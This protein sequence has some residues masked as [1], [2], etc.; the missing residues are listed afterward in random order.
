MPVVNEPSLVSFDANRAMEVLRETLGD[1]LLVV[2][3]YDRDGFNT[4]YVADVIRALYPDEG[5]M[6]E[7]FAGIHAY[8]YLDFTERELFED[9]FIESGGTRA[10]VTYMVNLVAIRVVRE[11]EGLF[12]SAVPGT[13][14]TEL[15]EL[16]EG[17]IR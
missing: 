7:H 13:P 1:D 5:A 11:T 15:V 4:L 16:V 12:L 10:F 14:V 9:L 6:Q 17:I 2:V 8:V 3:E